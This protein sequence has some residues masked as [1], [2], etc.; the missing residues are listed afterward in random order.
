MSEEEKNGNPHGANQ[1]KPDPR[2]A[3]FLSYYLDPKSGTFSNAYQSAI[4]AKFSEE[5]AQNI[6][7]QMPTWLSEAISDQSMLSKAERNLDKFL[8]YQE[9]PKIQADITKFVAK[10]LGKAKY[11]ERTETDI[12]SKGEQLEGIAVSFKKANETDNNPT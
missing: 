7:G 1:H 9:D 6:T 3:V 10:G 11:S 8:D 5:Y 12:T 2:Q 4:K